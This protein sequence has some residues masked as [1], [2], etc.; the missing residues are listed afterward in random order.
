LFSQFTIDELIPE[1][2][3]RNKIV[4]IR[5]VIF[6]GYEMSTNEAIELGVHIE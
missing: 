1:I 2:L 5:T 3:R 6:L 4:G